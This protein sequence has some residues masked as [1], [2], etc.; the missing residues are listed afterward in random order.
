MT[1]IEEKIGEQTG[2]IN[3]LTDSVREVTKLIPVVAVHENRLDDIEK[4]VVPK[5]DEHERKFN[6]VLGAA[7]VLGFLGSGLFKILDTA[8]AWFGGG[9]H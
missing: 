4:N 1:G 9:N 7:T 6:L 8:G 5:V 2:A 3:A